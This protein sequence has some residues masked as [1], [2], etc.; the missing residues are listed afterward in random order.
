MMAV[1]RYDVMSAELDLFMA[2]S[3]QGLNAPSP[4]SHTGRGVRSLKSSGMDLVAKRAGS[5]S[6]LMIV[7][8]GSNV[9]SS[10]SIIH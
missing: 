2:A 5:R 3:Q 1:T 8:K 9:I 10:T 6:S 4:P 7:S